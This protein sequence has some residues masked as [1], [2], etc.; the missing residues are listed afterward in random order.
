MENF[1]FEHFWR[2]KFIVAVIFS[3]SKT[4][5]AKFSIKHILKNLSKI[6]KKLKSLPNFTKSIR[7]FVTHCTHKIVIQIF[8]NNRN[9]AAEM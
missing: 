6:G 2:K 5:Y 9:S 8:K 4:L 3:S 7:K 1:I